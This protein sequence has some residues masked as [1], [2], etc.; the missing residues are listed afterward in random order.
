MIFVRISYLMDADTEEALREYEGLYQ[1]AACKSE[2]WTRCPEAERREHEIFTTSAACPAPGRNSSKK[3][4][5]GGTDAGR[6]NAEK[7][8]GD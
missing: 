5:E 3:R 8:P 6:S 4:K 2:F 1:S 7:P